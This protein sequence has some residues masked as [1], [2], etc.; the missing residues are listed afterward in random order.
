MKKSKRLKNYQNI[1]KLNWRV[2]WYGVFVWLLSFILSSVVMLPWFYV[3]YPLAILFVTYLFF[4]KVA[5]FKAGVNWSG[6]HFFE[7]GL[8]IGFFWFMAISVFDFIEFVGLDFANAPI[9]FLDPRNFIKY[10][11]VILI[12]IVYGLV[13][14]NQKSP[15]TK[16]DDDLITSGAVRL[17]T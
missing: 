4:R 1:F 11:V 6:G 10:P 9:Y 7:Q 17:H 8:S 2:A 5:Y 12:P 13:L 15:S 16:Y 3:L 14:E